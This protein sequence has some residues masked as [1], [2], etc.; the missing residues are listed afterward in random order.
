MKNEAARNGWRNS[1]Y[2]VIMAGGKGARFWPV[3]ADGN[4]KQ[5][6]N[7]LGSTSLLQ[8]TVSRIIP[9]IPL[10]HVCVVTKASLETQVR[11]QLAVFALP[12]NEDISKRNIIVEPVGR[13]T[14][15][16][17][18]LAALHLRRRYS[19]D[20][21]MVV[22]P[23]DH[24]IREKQRFH[25]LLEYARS[26][27][28]NH[29]V[30]LTFGI[31]PTLPETGYGYIHIGDVYH[32]QNSLQSFH[33]SE[34]VEKPNLNMAKEYLR[35]GTYLWNSGI[36]V[37]RVG[38][39]LD[40]IKTYQPSIYQKLMEIDRAIATPRETEVIHRAYSDMDTVS[41]DYGV[42]EKADDVLVIPADIGWNDVGNWAAMREVFEQDAS[43]NAVLGRYLSLDSRN[44]VI[45]SQ[46]KLIATIGLS[47]LI[48]VD[49]E[50]AV[51]VCPLERAQE[52]KDLV[53][54]IEDIRSRDTGSGNIE[55]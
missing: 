26:I 7:L 37:W 28:A 8:Q 15:P 9:L 48:I 18:G 52:V 24:I 21:V 13:N 32:V 22:L 31:I 46:N 16:C 55:G 3:S 38:I 39:I 42:M 5:L 6:L 10:E 41:I 49:S 47:D 14:L 23:S 45:Y 20:A 27:A 36:F 19:E 25:K 4:P 53:E 35:S 44:C 33:V 43:G 50:Q 51:L 2:A 34:F 29:G 40:A 1:M 12:S 30:L 54:R 17:I 11:E